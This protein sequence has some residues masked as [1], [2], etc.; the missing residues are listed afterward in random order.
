MEGGNHMQVK[1]NKCGYVGA[2]QTFILGRDMFQK[3]FV[4]GC[5]RCDNLQTPGGASMRMLPGSDHPFEYVR[6]TPGG[7]DYIEQVKHDA[8]EAS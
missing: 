5:P 1:C 4:A 6:E 7:G 2:K 3:E 8:G